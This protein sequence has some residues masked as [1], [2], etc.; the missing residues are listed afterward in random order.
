MTSFTP[1]DTL[2]QEGIERYQKVIFFAK[3]VTCLVLLPVSGVEL[4]ST[5]RER[6]EARREARRA[7]PGLGLL[8][9]K[10]PTPTS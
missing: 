9:S 2:R 8:G 3:N 1:V 10:P 4:E 6:K 7:E 5:L